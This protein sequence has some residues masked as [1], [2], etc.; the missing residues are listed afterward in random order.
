MTRDGVATDKSADAGAVVSDDHRT[1]GVRR[2]GGIKQVQIRIGNDAGFEEC[3]SCGT[4]PIP[5]NGHVVVDLG[6]MDGVKDTRHRINPGAQT[7]VVGL[8]GGG[9]IRLNGGKQGYPGVGIERNN[10]RTHIDA[11][12]SCEGCAWTG[13][14]LYSEAHQV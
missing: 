9:A 7:R 13:G 8:E 11:G 6:A 4:D 5:T 10:I 14:V 2:D 12:G 3:V 1:I